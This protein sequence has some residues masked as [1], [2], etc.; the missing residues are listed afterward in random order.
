MQNVEAQPIQRTIVTHFGFKSWGHW[1]SPLSGSRFLPLEFHKKLC[2]SREKFPSV[3]WTTTPA[4]YAL[5]GYP[6]TTGDHDPDLVL[7]LSI[8]SFPSSQHFQL[9][10]VLF[11]FSCLCGC[12]PTKPH[13][14]EP[15]RGNRDQWPLEWPIPL[16]AKPQNVDFVSNESGKHHQVPKKTIAP[17]RDPK[18]FGGI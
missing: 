5:G 11:G 6:A 12:K 15:G 8:L 14:A 16:A 18:Q 3:V 4:D 2:Q 9:R 1:Q 17:A 13:S 10:S 7:H